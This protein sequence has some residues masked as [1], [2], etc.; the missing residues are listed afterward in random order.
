MADL[1]VIIPTRNRIG[2]LFKCLE[3]LV[4]QDCS[5]DKFEI[6]VVEDGCSSNIK[7]LVNDIAVCGNNIRYLSNNKK[8]GASATR[9]LGLKICHSEII[10]FVDDDCRLPANWVR[11]ILY[12]HSKYPDA[13]V[14]QGEVLAD[15]LKSIFEISEYLIYSV[16]FKKSIYEHN[17]I[18]SIDILNAAN[19]SLKRSIIDDKTLFFREDFKFSEDIDLSNRILSKGTIFFY[20]EDIKAYHSYSSDIFSFIRR[21]IRDGRGEYLIKCSKGAPK[22]DKIT[23]IR[24][25]NFFNFMVKLYF[26][27]FSIGKSMVL[28]QLHIL[29]CLLRRLGFVF[30]LVV[31]AIIKT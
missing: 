15:S 25:I 1:G 4:K 28:T 10:A 12:Y 23:G 31:M 24:G 27:E 16:F 14:I 29:R 11:N 9:N 3:S 6:F 20:V 17:G 2:P 21:G 26:R 19:L 7:G 30:Q 5:K 8:S 13:K 18:K 22:Q